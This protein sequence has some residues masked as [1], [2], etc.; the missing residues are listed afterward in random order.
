MS[1]RSGK[2]VTLRESSTYAA[3]NTWYE[4]VNEIKLWNDADQL[5]LYIKCDTDDCGLV[6][7]KAQTLSNDDAWCDVVG[8]GQ[9]WSPGLMLSGQKLTINLCGA[10]FCEHDRIKIFF[11]CSR[12]AGAAKL[13]IQG[14]G[15]DSRA[16]ANPLLKEHGGLPVETKEPD[17]E[18]VDFYFIQLVQAPTQTTADA[19]ENTY[20]ITV[21]AGSGAIVGD[22]IG[23]FFENKFYFGEAL[24]VTG[25]GTIIGLDSPLNYSYL[26]G[27]QVTIATRDL[28]VDGSVTRQ[29]FNIGPVFD[30][31][32]NKIRIRNLIFQMT[33]ATAMDDGKFGGIAGGLV[34]GLFLRSNTTD[35]GYRN[36][37]NLKT[38]GDFANIAYDTIYADKAPAGLYGFKT[39]YTYAGR[40]KHGSAPILAAGDTMDAIV[41]DDLT[42]LDSFRIIARGE[43]FQ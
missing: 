18:T 17:N 28:N 19:I 31:Q 12:G 27:S 21:P 5:R 11:R 40:E 34:N 25:G 23:I 37:F 2:K 35:H 9:P 4:C 30:F 29:S 8:P 13:E 39:K 7:I 32:D 38:N 22:Y 20:S 1:T 6:E 43:V 16:W 26:T 14:L 3:N 10:G 41:Q 42:L 36:Y 15:H 24:S 33:D